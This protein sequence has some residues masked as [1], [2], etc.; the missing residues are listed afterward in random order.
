M[1]KFLLG[2]NAK[3]YFGAALLS[4]S[5]TPANA[6]WTEL[7]NVRDVSVNV[8]VGE[9]DVTARDAGGWEEIAATLKSG[10]VEFE[11][12]WRPSDPGFE[13]VRDALLNDSELAIMALDQAKETAGAQG[14]AANMMVTGFRRGEELRNAII[15]SVTLKPSSFTQ[16]YQAAGTTTTTTT[17]GA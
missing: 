4:Q 17:T 6:D 7:G 11:M 12:V 8:E 16:W 14:L 10:T 2:K 9:A 13:A 5:V 1:A 3:M 15:V